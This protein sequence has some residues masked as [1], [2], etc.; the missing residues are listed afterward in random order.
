MFVLL[1]SPI[2]WR[3]VYL[4]HHTLC[5]VASTY[6][7][8]TSRWALY[9]PAITA[10][11]LCYPFCYYTAVPSSS[12][13]WSCT[14]ILL[15]KSLF[16]MYTAFAVPFRIVALT[17][18]SYFYCWLHCLQLNG[19]YRIFSL[20]FFLLVLICSSTLVLRT[21]FSWSLRTLRLLSC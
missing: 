17:A 21:H 6:T 3:F 13:F 12:S 2:L 7:T 14:P 1:Y 20:E 9:K 11:S 10:P 19:T 15:M 4:Q 18:V 8:T 16:R 5:V